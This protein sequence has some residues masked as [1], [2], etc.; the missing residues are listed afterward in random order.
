MP[1]SHLFPGSKD[2]NFGYVRGTI[3]AGL[4]DVFL[5]LFGVAQN[6]HVFA[7]PIGKKTL[8]YI[9]PF[10]GQMGTAVIDLG[11]DSRWLLNRELRADEPYDSFSYYH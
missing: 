11:T 6:R 7:V 10:G 9:A 1:R 4:P 2:L 5:K 8:A 3:D